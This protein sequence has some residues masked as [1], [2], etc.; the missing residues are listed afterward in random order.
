MSLRSIIF[1]SFYLPLD[2]PLLFQDSYEI[3]KFTVWEKYMVRLLNVKADTK[4]E[5]KVSGCISRSITS[6]QTHK[7]WISWDT[8]PLTNYLT[9]TGTVLL[10]WHLVPHKTWKRV[11]SLSYLAVG[12]WQRLINFTSLV[13]VHSIGSDYIDRYCVII[14]IV[15][16]IWFYMGLFES[17]MISFGYLSRSSLESCVLPGRLMTSVIA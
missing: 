14:S 8:L 4:K 17:V 3:H 5:F 12:L 6:P 16:L 9:C 7:T 13:I 11:T 10:F 2:L 15:I 1:S